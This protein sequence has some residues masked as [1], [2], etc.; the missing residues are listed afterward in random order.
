MV[1]HMLQLS[2]EELFTSSSSPAPDPDS[3]S[4]PPYMQASLA[5]KVSFR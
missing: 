3:V 2:E 5:E 1:A 4:I